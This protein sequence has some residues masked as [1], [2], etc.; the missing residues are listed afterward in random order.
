M[1]GW[2]TGAHAEALGTLHPAGIPK[3]RQRRD[4][5]HCTL[6]PP[7]SN[8]SLTDTGVKYVTF[9][10]KDSKTNWTKYLFSNFG[11]SAMLQG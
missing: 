11:N 8:D 7:T 1:E 6:F 10:S 9:S 5:A 3:P 2:Q 4:P